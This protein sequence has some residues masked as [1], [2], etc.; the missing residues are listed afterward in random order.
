MKL[1]LITTLEEFDETIIRNL[2]TLGYHVTVIKVVS[3]S[4]EA[5]SEA[6]EG[7]EFDYAIVP[8][9]SPHDY[10]GLEFKVVKGSVSPYTLPYILSLASPRVLSPK[11]QAEKVLGPNV[12]A[13]V[14]ERVYMDILSSLE[15]AF[16][17]GGLKVPRK[18]PPILVASD[19]YV[20]ESRVGDAAVEESSY[21]LSEG[22]D[23]IVL[24]SHPT[25]NS[26]L[27]LDTLEAVM[28]SLGKPVA[29]DPARLETLVEA[30][31][32]GAQIAMSLTPGDLDRIPKT[33]RDKAAYVIIPGETS[34]W[35]A[36]VDILERAHSRALELGYNSV[37]LDPI[38]NPPVYRG[39]LDS[40]IASR[41]LSK[42]GAPIMLGLNNAVEMAD[43]DTHASTATLIMLACE[44]GAS[45][46]M[47]GEESYKARGNTREAARAARMASISLK[48]KTPPKD[49]GIS[50]LDFKGKNPP[51][52][53][54]YLGRGRVKIKKLGLEVNCRDK[55]SLEELKNYWNLL[56]EACRPWV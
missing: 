49:M 23:I 20:T 42:L 29:A 55:N 17:V 46:V 11:V 15:P 25:L 56:G 6:L 10:G 41:I 36:R 19:I 38:V 3:L 2:E 5:L 1:A 24:S 39:T 7:L 16:T 54:E 22:A 47:V 14:A 21:R 32:M 28:S 50:I 30:V 48:L 18:P 9:S 37:I 51:E 27:Y 53:L 26:R 40:L 45:I 8:G 4:P 12:M 52:G 13:E 44:A 34:N 31:D 33:L 43:I 35:E